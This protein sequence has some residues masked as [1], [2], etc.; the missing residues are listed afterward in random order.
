[1]VGQVDS[2]ISALCFVIGHYNASLAAVEN[3]RAALIDH[4]RAVDL[5]KLARVIARKEIV[6]IIQSYRVAIAVRQVKLANL[7]A[8]VEA[9]QQ[10]SAVSLVIITQLSEKATALNSPAKRC[11]YLDLV[12]LFLSATGQNILNNDFAII[13][14]TILKVDKFVRVDYSG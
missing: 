13:I 6:G 5:E 11:F 8:A 3:N 4:T 7:F 10:P 14:G 9:N 1:M 2:G 12:N